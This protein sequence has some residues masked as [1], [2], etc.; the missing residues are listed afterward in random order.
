MGAEIKP[1]TFLTTGC[2]WSVLIEIRVV[3]SG[4]GDPYAATHYKRIHKEI[5]GGDY[6]SDYDGDDRL[7]ASDSS[8]DEGL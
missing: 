4:G 2:S 1:E 3:V 8:E 6:V 5:T 7:S